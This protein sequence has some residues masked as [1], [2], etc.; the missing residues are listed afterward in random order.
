[1]TDYTGISEEG[2]SGMFYVALSDERRQ[3]CHEVFPRWVKPDG[4]N[5]NVP[6]QE[7]YISKDVIGQYAIGVTGELAVRTWQI[8][9]WA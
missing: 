7:F 9:S 4:P 3:N 8:V 5:G 6:S 1:L 2:Q